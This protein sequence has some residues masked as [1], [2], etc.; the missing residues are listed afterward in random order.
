MVKPVV[1][2]LATWCL[3]TLLVVLGWV[4]WDGVEG[5]RLHREARAFRGTAATQADSGA[6]AWR[7]YLAADVVQTAPATFNDP[8]ITALRQAASSGRA[9]EPDVLEAAAEIVERHRV[10]LWL[11][12]EAASMPMGPVPSESEYLLRYVHL[13]R[14]DHLQG[15]AMLYALAQGRHEDALAIAVSR[16]RLLRIW[17]RDGDI[18]NV[19]MKARTG[20]TILADIGL[21]LGQPL[22]PSHVDDLDVNLAAAFSESDIEEALRGDALWLNDKLIPTLAARSPLRPLWRRAGVAAHRASAACVTAAREP[23]PERLTRMR[24]IEGDHRYEWIPVGGQALAT[25]GIVDRCNRVA[26]AV[27]RSIAGVH[28][29]RAALRIERQRLATGRLPDSLDDSILSG[30][31]DPF[32]G[33]PL[34]YR[35]EAD[36]FTVYS[37]GPDGSDDGGEVTA[38]ATP[39]DT[40]GVS[41]ARDAGVRVRIR[42]SG[43]GS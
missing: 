25:H 7:L 17:E 5:G 15:L 10:A 8:I 33:R 2:R 23:W 30:T 1:R 34:L 31:V 38:A 29:V 21:T 39:G 35:K 24:A 9:P 6:S 12:R 41:P 37:V 27:A 19:M 3:P 11:A 20:D 4:V 42:R 40:I 32:T 18:V 14:L 26:E 13:R 43:P 36:G 16:I 28:A 22:P